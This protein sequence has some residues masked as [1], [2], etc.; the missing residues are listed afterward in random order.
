MI[1]KTFN[2]EIDEK[3][4]NY[5]KSQAEPLIDTPNSVLRRLLFGEKPSAISQDNPITSM[6]DLLKIP[7]YVPKA[8]SQVL[9]VLYFIRNENLSREDATRWVAKRKNTGYQ[10]IIDKY[11]R[12]LG[13]KARDIDKLL[14]EEDLNEF[15]LL[16]SEKF[17]NH[18]K[19]IDKFFESL[20]SQ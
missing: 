17:T 6:P 1:L 3:V 19:L 4:W 2:I 15:K 10:T 5:L 14:M 9:E 12:Q 7:N 8:L 13:K 20:N 18:I 16:L 11:T